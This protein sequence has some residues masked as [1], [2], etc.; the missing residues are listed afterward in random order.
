MKK[1]ELPKDWDEQRVRKVLDHYERHPGIF[2]H[3]LE[4][5]LDGFQTA[6][7][8]PDADIMGRLAVGF[9]WGDNGG[10]LIRP[11]ILAC[12]S[13]ES[14]TA[15]GEDHFGSPAVVHSQ[16]EPATDMSSRPLRLI[17]AS[18]SATASRLI[19]STLSP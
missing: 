15:A 13:T 7:R 9:F 12:S 14:A 16:I 6:C 10:C 17:A 5:R 1:E 3:V 4:K 18:A 11:R 8:C 19:A 2:G